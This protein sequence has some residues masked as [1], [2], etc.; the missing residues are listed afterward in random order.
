LRALYGSREIRD[1]VPDAVPD[2]A[3][4]FV[5]GPYVVRTKEGA[6]NI[7][8]ALENVLGFINDSAEEFVAA[9]DLLSNNSATINL[10]TLPNTIHAANTG[11]LGATTAGGQV[12]DEVNITALERMKKFKRGGQFTPKRW[13][14]VIRMYADTR[15]EERE[16]AEQN[17]TVGG[18]MEAQHYVIILGELTNFMSVFKNE[19]IGGN[20]DLAQDS[21][22]Y[23]TIRQIYLKGRLPRHYKYASP[24]VPWR[25]DDQVS[26]Q[27]YSTS[28]EYAVD[29][30]V[31][32]SIV[33]SMCFNVPLTEEKRLTINETNSF[34]FLHTFCGPVPF[35]YCNCGRNS[36]TQLSL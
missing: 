20:E 17:R 22:S 31:V 27:R 18:K 4:E 9:L 12:D 1:A 35:Q 16:A 19:R 13:G 15:W 5:A 6:G 30:P 28:S 2:S 25:T 21:I 8:S 36:Q 29:V 26:D 3:E 24:D 34:N 32:Q 10:R 7:L 33:Q 14:K 23:S 11:I